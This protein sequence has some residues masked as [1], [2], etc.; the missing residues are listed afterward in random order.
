MT[1]NTITDLANL[2]LDD[3]EKQL[4][5][6][7]PAKTIGRPATPFKTSDMAPP[8][9]KFPVT[10]EERENAFY[11]KKRAGYNHRVDESVEFNGFCVF[12]NGLEMDENSEIGYPEEAAGSLVYESGFGNEW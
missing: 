7:E 10:Y 9:N 2:S 8:I 6:Y 3:L 11:A 1:D 5:V 4:T 12:A